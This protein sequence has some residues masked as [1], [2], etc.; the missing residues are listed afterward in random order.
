MWC[1][2]FLAC[3]DAL[4][5]AWQVDVKPVAR[6][7]ILR[8]PAC[9]KRKKQEGML[10][11]AVAY[12][13]IGLVQDDSASSTGSVCPIK[14]AQRTRQKVTKRR[15]TL[16]SILRTR[17]NSRQGLGDLACSSLPMCPP[18]ASSAPPHSIQ[19]TAPRVTARTS[20]QRLVRSFWSWVQSYKR[21]TGEPTIA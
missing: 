4:R 11:H 6:W 10:Q 3:P 1:F 13:S 16:W 12:D 2:G 8:S 18:S 14:R 15:S 7:N 19:S 21:W 9:R 5:P 20:K 17:A